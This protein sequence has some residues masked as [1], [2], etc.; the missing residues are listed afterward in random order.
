MN[1]PKERLGARSQ[2]CPNPR[3]RARSTASANAWA[4]R[5]TSVCTAPLLG[6][7]RGGIPAENA[8]PGRSPD[9]PAFPGTADSTSPSRNRRRASW[10]EVAGT[11]AEAVGPLGGE[12]GW[13]GGG[14][15][16]WRRRTAAGPGRR[17]RTAARSAAGTLWRRRTDRI[18]IARERE[19]GTFDVG[20]LSDDDVDVADNAL[21]EAFLDAARSA[22]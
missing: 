20:L 2:T 1:P 12:G 8:C 14:G 22:V 16:R 13:G 15:R 6:S 17:A 21:A 7:R 5:C 9:F 4:T 18:R 3:D 19:L 11:W 10:A